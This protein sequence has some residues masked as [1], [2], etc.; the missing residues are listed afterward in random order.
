MGY[1]D[2]DALK[3]YNDM[4]HTWFSVDLDS[5]YAS[6][7][8]LWVLRASHITPCIIPLLPRWLD[9]STLANFPNEPQ[10]YFLLR[11]PSWSS[12]VF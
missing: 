5:S 8:L 10:V 7:R 3:C 9:S 4:H 6:T 1:W 12:M 2:V 11:D